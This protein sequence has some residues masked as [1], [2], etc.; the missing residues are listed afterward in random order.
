V[1]RINRLVLIIRQDTGYSGT[2]GWGLGVFSRVGLEFV[3]KKAVWKAAESVIPGLNM[4]HARVP[5]AD[6]RGGP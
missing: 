3:Q 1:M 4:D 2:R 5:G 6:V